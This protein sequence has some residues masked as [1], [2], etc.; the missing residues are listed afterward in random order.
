[1]TINKIALVIIILVTLS[2]CGVSQ[3]D[4]DKLALKYETARTG[5]DECQFG[6]EKLTAAIEK[7]YSKKN[8]SEARQKIE[9]LREKHPESPKNKDFSELLKK[10]EQEEKVENARLEA[11]KKERVRLANL[12]NTGIWSISYYVDEFG[13]KT[14]DGYVTNSDLI[15]GSFSN[16]AT[17]NSALNVKILIT[18]S[19]DISM[20]L[21]EYAGNNPVKAYSSDNY[22]VF[23]QDKDGKRIKLR[24]VNYSD[25]L[26]FANSAS[27]QVHNALLKGGTI[28][29]KII[30]DETPTT[31]YGFTIQNADWYSNAY[32]KFRK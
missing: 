13:E 12:D 25:R 31:E 19:S 16:T 7:A 2:S 17:Q 15:S 29:M 10:I 1:M 3:A 22:T 14:N 9:I 20:K 21:F 6:A 11:E 23:L 30:E 24:A 27:K 5:L 8:F 28:K 18:N 32:S 26:S 4:Y